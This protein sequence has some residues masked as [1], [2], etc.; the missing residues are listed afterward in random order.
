M[1]SL[2]RVQIIGRLGK[3]PLEKTTRKGTKLTVFT[4]AVDR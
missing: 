1:P 2:N 3:D 4:V